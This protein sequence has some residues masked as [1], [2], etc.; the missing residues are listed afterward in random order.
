MSCFAMT[1]CWGITDVL[2]SHD[3]VVGTTDVLCNHDVLCN[4][5]PVLGDHICRNVGP[6]C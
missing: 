5:D 3:L 4:Y 2:C 6:V 1:L